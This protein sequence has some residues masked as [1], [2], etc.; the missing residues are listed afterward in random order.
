MS[1]QLAPSR[2]TPLRDLGALVLLSKGTTVLTL[3]SILNGIAAAEFVQIFDA[4][5]TSDVTLGTTVPDLEIG[6]TA[7]TPLLLPLVGGVRF[8]KGIVVACTTTEKGATPTGAG[9]QCHA[10]IY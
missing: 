7:S 10:A 2:V 1:E 6:L 5:Q 8:M 9:V 4:V 3:L